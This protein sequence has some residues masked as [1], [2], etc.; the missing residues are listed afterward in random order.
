MGT[1]PC[2]RNARSHSAWLTL[3]WVHIADSATFI[4]E[5]CHGFYAVIAW[6][7]CI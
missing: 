6:G 5:V 7:D 2:G 1:R 3:N 4:R